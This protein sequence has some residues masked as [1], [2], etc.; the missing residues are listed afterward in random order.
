MKEARAAALLRS[1]HVAVTYDIG[2]HEGNLFIV[3]E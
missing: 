2:E 1:P 3:M